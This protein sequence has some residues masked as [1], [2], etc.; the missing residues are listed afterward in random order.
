MS[1][2]R[3]TLSEVEGSKTFAD[4]Y[5]RFLLVTTWTYYGRSC[6]SADR[7]RSFAAALLRVTPRGV[8][9]LSDG[10]ASP[11]SRPALSKEL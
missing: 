9:S 10:A 6:S 1:E 8:V 7:L 4:Y 5:N 2:A 3:V 11:R